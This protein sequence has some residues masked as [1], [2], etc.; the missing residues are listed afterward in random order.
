MIKDFIIYE[1]HIIIKPMAGVNHLESKWT[2]NEYI[3]TNLG[4]YDCNLWE[5]AVTSLNQNYH[6]TNFFTEL[7]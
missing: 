3:N 2:Q 5:K 6:E 4:D 1:I 7:Y